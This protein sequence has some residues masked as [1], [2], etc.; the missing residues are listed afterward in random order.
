[1]KVNKIDKFQEGITWFDSEDEFEE[2]N[3]WIVDGST[4]FCTNIEGDGDYEWHDELG[5]E[6]FFKT[7][8]KDLAVEFF[9]AIV[10]EQKI[11]AY[12]DKQWRQ[13]KDESDYAEWRNDELSRV[14]Y[15]SICE[16]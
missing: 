16:H 6:T 12:D 7:R 8:N 4:S 14:D 1:M 5:Y 10:I 13:T 2:G 15:I 11:D 3:Y 9:K